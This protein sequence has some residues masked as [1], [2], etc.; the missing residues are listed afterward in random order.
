MADENP[1]QRFLGGSPGAVLLKLALL[2]LLVGVL[3]AAFGFSPL[4]FLRFLR[5]M[6]HDIFGFGM[7]AVHRL[8]GYILAGA[9]IV[10]PLWLLIRLLARK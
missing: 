9:V 3:L 1:L 5:E 4:G 7:D 10:V 6:F 8:F 2:S